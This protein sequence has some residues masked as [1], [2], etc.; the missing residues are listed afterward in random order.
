MR[1]AAC[2]AL[3]HASK[4][5]AKSLCGFISRGLTLWVQNMVPVV[6][7]R[8]QQQADQERD[9]AVEVAFHRVVCTVW[10]GQQCLELLA[11]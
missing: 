1:I 8:L 4:V 2:E 3:S 11:L 9:S 5:S 6:M 7:E 10:Y